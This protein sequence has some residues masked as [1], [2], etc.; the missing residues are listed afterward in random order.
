M[1]TAA[2][3][4]ISSKSS[5]LGSISLQLFVKPNASAAREGIVSITPSAI[6]LAIA[7]QPKDGEANKAVI[8]LLS[9]VL[10]VPKARL[11][12]RRGLKSKEKTVILDNSTEDSV[13]SIMDILRNASAS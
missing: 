5:A 8:Q 4:F 10:G 6:H 9:D 1:S 11:H 13:T 12:L 7:A 2:V 3:R